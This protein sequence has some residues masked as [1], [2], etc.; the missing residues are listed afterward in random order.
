MSGKVIGLI[1]VVLMVVGG[2]GAYVATQ[3]KDDEKAATATNSKSAFKDPESD[4]YNGDLLDIT[5]AGKARK[6][7]FQSTVDNVTSNGT[8]YTDGR[9]RG[10]M[11]IVVENVGSTN[12]LVLSD[13]IYGWT[14]A[15]GST[16]GF[17][18]TKAELQKMSTDASANSQAN[19]AASSANQA[20]NM[21]CT[22]WTLDLSKFTVPTNINFL[23]LPSGQ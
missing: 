10:L 11:E 16:T 5:S 22:S 18:Y 19:S 9:G 21:K 4:V 1:V 15:G 2:V 3:N 7:T 20:F 14:T 17:T 13:K 6:C 12:V 8:L 23:S